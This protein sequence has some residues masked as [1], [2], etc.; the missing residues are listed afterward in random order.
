[1]RSGAIQD[2]AFLTTS[3]VRLSALSLSSGAEA[4]T[5]V[6]LPGGMDVRRSTISLMLGLLSTSSVKQSCASGANC[7]QRAIRATCE[8]SEAAPTDLCL[9]VPAV[10]LMRLL[11]AAIQAGKQSAVHMAVVMQP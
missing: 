5:S 8:G 11:S 7:C 2:G 3:S 1:M 4:R 6:G 10:T 9:T